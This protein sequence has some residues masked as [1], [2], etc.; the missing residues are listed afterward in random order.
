MADRLAEFVAKN[1]RKFEEITRDRNKPDGPFRCVRIALCTYTL[2][3]T[4]WLTQ[5][6][7]VSVRS[8]LARP[9]LLP[10]QAARGRAADSGAHRG[11]AVAP[12][13][14]ACSHHAGGGGSSSS[15]S[16][17]SGYRAS[18][19][20]AECAPCVCRGLRLLSTE[21]LLC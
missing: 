14:T 4:A 12:G 17:G 19:A 16:S 2:A 7:Q 13:T 21:H 5:C 11:S 18:A 20:T 6:V 15:S 3:A 8:W 9:P 1:G 10:A